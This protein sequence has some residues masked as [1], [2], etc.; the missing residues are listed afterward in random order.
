LRLKEQ[1]RNLELII[2]PF[3]SKKIGKKQRVELCQVGKFLTLLDYYPH[4]VKHCASPDFIISYNGQIIG[5][6]H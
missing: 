5:L 1:E 6:E 2:K 3:L 4:I